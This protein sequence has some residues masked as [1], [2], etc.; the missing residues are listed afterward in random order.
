M[1]LPHVVIFLVLTGTSNV[2][3]AGVTP[4]RLPAGSVLVLTP[5]VLNRDSELAWIGPAI[6][7][8]IV[9]DLSRHLPDPVL[10][11]ANSA[12]GQ[13]EAIA[14][15]KQASV[16]K[17]ISGSVQIIGDQ[18]RFTGGIVD[19]KGGRVIAPL[20]ATGRLS[21]L[22]EMEDQLSGQASRALIVYEPSPHTAP[23]AITASGPLRASYAVP[24]SQAGMEYA[25]PYANNRFQAE[26]NRYFYHGACWGCGYGCGGC[27]GYPGWGWFGGWCSPYPTA[28]PGWAW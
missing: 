1:F 2:L 9:T 26:Q 13:G 7:Q 6:Q 23:M 3:R 16:P 21:D 28:S 8:S 22:F 24:G 12:V 20:K 27:W 10:M 14:V 15:G 19:V 11:S 17:V 18:I 5:A 25:T 4:V